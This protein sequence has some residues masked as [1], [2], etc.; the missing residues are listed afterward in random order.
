M[1]LNTAAG[2]ICTGQ[3]TASGNLS[4]GRGVCRNHH[5]QAI[6]A[7]AQIRRPNLGPPPVLTTDVL[8]FD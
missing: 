3:I 4:D 1:Q 5:V 2:L 8:G 7:L 6:H